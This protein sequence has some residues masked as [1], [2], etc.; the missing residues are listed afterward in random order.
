MCETEG[1]PL[2]FLLNHFKFND[3]KLKRFSKFTDLNFYEKKQTEVIKPSEWKE[4]TKGN[5]PE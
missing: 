4:S 2:P 5:A 1:I 3:R